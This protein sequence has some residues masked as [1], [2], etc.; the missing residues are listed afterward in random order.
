MAMRTRTRLLILVGALL[1]IFPIAQLYVSHLNE[2]LNKA[3]LRINRD[4]KTDQLLF[5]ID[6]YGH[7][8]RTLAEDYSWWD[9]MVHYVKSPTTEWAAANMYTGLVAFEAEG[10]WIFDA[11]TNLVFSTS[12]AEFSE[13]ATD[14][15]V[16]VSIRKLIAKGMF[17]QVYHSTR[18][19]VVS[20]Y[21]APIQLQSDMDRSSEP[22]GYL[23]V[24]DHWNELALAKLATLMR[25]EV[26]LSQKTNT[27]GV[28]ANTSISEDQL[29]FACFATLRGIDD[30]PVAEI[31]CIT[32]PPAYSE[33]LSYDK[34]LLLGVWVL[35]AGVV[36]L[37]ILALSRWV[38]RPLDQIMR[39]LE[40]QDYKQLK[41][42]KSAGSDFQ[43]IGLMVK[44]FFD[45]KIELEHQLAVSRDVEA[46][47]RA[48][49]RLQQLEVRKTELVLQSAGEGICGV[50]RV[51]RITFIN[52]AAEKMLGWEPGELLGKNLHEKTHHTRAKGSPYPR[53]E[54]PVFVTISKGRLRRSSNETFWRKDGSRFPVELVSAPI[55]E[56]GSSIGA[57]VVF[58]DLTAQKKAEEQLGKLWL[59]MEQSPS[60]IMITDTNGTI[61]NVNPK[62]LEITGFSADEV[63]GATPRIVK[64][65]F[66]SNEFY[67]QLWETLSAGRIWHGE[68]CNRKKN[69]DLYWES[70]AIAPVRNMMGEVTHFV[71]VKE[72]VSDRKKADQEIKE[73]KE[74]AESANRAKSAFL[75]SMSHEIRTP[76]NSIL[77]YTQLL[78]RDSSLTRQ[79]RQYVEIVNRSGEHLLELINDVLEMSKI[80]SGRITIE[81]TSFSL[82][83]MINDIAAM[84]QIRAE[85]KQLDFEVVKTGTTQPW[86]TTDE[87][88]LRQILINL[89]G[90]AI[91]FT[92]NGRIALKVDVE[93]PIVGTGRLDV[94]VEDTGS[95]ISPDELNK[96]FKHFEQTES[97]RRSQAGTG[98][99]LAIS[100]EY[101][102]LLGGD[103]TVTSIVGIGSTFRLE[104]PIE[105]GEKVTVTRTRES[106]RIIG[107]SL[108]HCT[109]CPIRVLVVDD[110]RLNRGWIRDVLTEVGFKVREAS[111]GDE[112]IQVWND[113]KPQLILMDIHM[114]PVDGKD[115]TMK[116]RS[117]N[118][119]SDTAIIGLSASAFAEDVESALTAGMNAFLSKPVKLEELFEVIRANLGVEYSYENEETTENGAQTTQ[120]LARVSAEQLSRLSESMRTQL[121]EATLHG[122]VERLSQVIAEIFKIDQALANAL[123][124]LV[125]QYD[126]DQILNLSQGATV[127]V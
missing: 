122:D 98:L 110:N 106:R 127:K 43:R 71:A 126:Y 56:G 114:S 34:R 86:I 100:R 95:G 32:S 40:K 8:L 14:P 87:G 88:K 13:L 69:G 17:K 41:S 28:P 20:L 66:H 59:A 44:E 31:T 92:R 10:A 93:V 108:N 99:G 105:A 21:S 5:A 113:W 50:D 64:S 91:K 39:G 29:K 103:I 3:F 26:S 54:C 90:N 120:P 42:L 46:A 123:T 25:A 11:D 67:R 124:E 68:F 80:E 81:R 19:G 70:S 112:A 7:Q 82:N 107:L 118:G 30:E 36:I 96:L 76:M 45:Q 57:V 117:A 15:D 24:A 53:E 85:S 60:S 101:A 12:T 18:R 119:G 78:A 55:L 97:G 79:S 63:I 48:V 16:R 37:L 111:D 121:R 89:L 94:S 115:A 84:F 47:L 58:R 6:M 1:L 61:E 77:G 102:R 52:A 38:N 49:E 116:I 65:G 125:D 62:F 35:T 9:E 2:R 27:F 72:D 4:E 104:I 33:I 83:S 22:A 23:V 74:L 75:A 73:A 109:N 51:G